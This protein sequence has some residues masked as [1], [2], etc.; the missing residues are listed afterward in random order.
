M[1]QDR[2]ALFNIDQIPQQKVVRLYNLGTWCYAI[3]SINIIISSPSVV[4][5]IKNCHNNNQNRTPIIQELY[6]LLMLENKEIGSIA[7]ILKII[8]R[9]HST[10]FT[11]H[12][13]QDAEFLTRLLDC[14]YNSILESDKQ[15]F[16]MLFKT[17]NEKK[18]IVYC[19][20]HF[21]LSN[22]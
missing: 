15:E 10:D 21:W 9:N 7:E 12:R 2:E 13:Q 20:Q 8:L 4:T 11:R 16:M 17:E 1:S 19:F 14:L 3:G 18:K 22:C 5:F 6:G